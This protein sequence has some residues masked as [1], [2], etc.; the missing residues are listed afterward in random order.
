M[1]KTATTQV[2]P[3]LVADGVLALLYSSM[4][5]INRCRA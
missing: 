5:R 1:K 2:V 4:E 3:Y